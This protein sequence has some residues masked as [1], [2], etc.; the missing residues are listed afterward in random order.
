MNTVQNSQND[1]LEK[2]LIERIKRKDEPAFEEFVRHFQGMV[3]NLLYRYVRSVPDAE[4]LAQDV[5]VRI[6]N[7]AGS[8]RGDSRV[9]TW[10]FRI[11]SNLAINYL[12][13]KKLKQVS[14][15]V[16]S[17]LKGDRIKDEISDSS[18]RRSVTENRAN[19]IESA[20]QSL[21]P[22]Q[23]IAFILSK[24]EKHSYKEISEIMKVSVPAVESLLFRAKQNLRVFL[25]P[26]RENGKI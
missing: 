22:N 6:W 8:F 16:S 21:P 14:L 10:I 11:A 23:K 12:K 5:F 26:Y 9:S 24:H 19:L 15:D 17:S 18:G 25:L 4:E 7:S 2:S 1:E 13:K 3:L 20:V